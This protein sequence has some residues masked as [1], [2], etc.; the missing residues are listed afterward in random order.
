MNKTNPLGLK[1]MNQWNI[2]SVD[3]A[4]INNIRQRKHIK[5]R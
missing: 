2:S 5:T 3:T 1:K 4:A